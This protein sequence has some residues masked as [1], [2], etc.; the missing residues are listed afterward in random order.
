MH[1]DTLPENLPYL[2]EFLLSLEN[3]NY[4]KETVDN[5]LRDLEIFASFLAYRRQ[6]FLDVD[7]LLIS[8]FKGFLRNQNYIPILRKFKAG[9]EITDADEQE[10]YTNISE[11]KKALYRGQLAARSVNRMLSALRSYLN[12]LVDIDEDVPIPPSAIKMIKAEKKEKQVAD[13]SDL[14]R[15]IEAPMEY[16]KS[17]LPKLRNRAVLELIFATGMRISEV[18]NLNRDQIRIQQ[19]K[20]L[21]DRIYVIGKGKKQRFVYLT[22]RAITY[23]EEYLAEREDDYPAMFIP[24]KGTRRATANP[25]VVRLSQNYIQMKIADYRKKLGIIVPTSAHSLRHGFATY[26]AEEG[27]S[28]VAIQK[29]LG[30]ESLQTTTRYVHASDRF[31]EKA[32]RDFHP[33]QDQESQ[34]EEVTP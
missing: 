13:F 30:H 4:S 28:P 21:D 11:K 6:K 18:A 20:I 33:L 16:E 12:F 14:I 9:K 25:Y 29:L 19:G 15:L 26:L 5:Y 31:A 24:T 10:S 17:K 32:H 2:R 3:N 7:K 22:P 23:L 8:E 1:V 34:E 27:A